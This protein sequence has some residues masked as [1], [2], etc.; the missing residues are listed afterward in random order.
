MA[1]NFIKFITRTVQRGAFLKAQWVKNTL[2]QIYSR[3]MTWAC[4][5]QNINGFLHWG[6][7]FW[8]DPV[9]FGLY[10]S[11]R[12]KG[13]GY[14]VYPDVKNNSLLM[15]NRAIQTIEGIQDWELLNMYAK[16][17]PKEALNIAKKA[18]K[19]FT[20]FKNDAVL[21]DELRLKLLNLLE[22]V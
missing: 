12:Y 19:T 16:Y 20:D 2:A 8:E 7:S 17:N 13:D 15:S 22:E 11:A 14:I 10:P 6:G 1:L 5:S 9:S 18:A 21:L 4:F 3:L